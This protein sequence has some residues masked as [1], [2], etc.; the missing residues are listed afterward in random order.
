[1]KPNWIKVPPIPG[2]YRSLLKWGDPSVMKHPTPRLYE[3]LKMTFA[4]EDAD[5]QKPINP[6]D[7]AI[8]KVLPVNLKKSAISFFRTLLGE[9]NILTDSF[10][11]IKASYGK[12]TIDAWRLRDKRVEHVPDVVLRPRNAEDVQQIV[13][14][15][16]RNKIAIYPVGGRSS[17]TAAFEAVKKGI[18]LDMTA[19]MN[20]VLDFDEQNQTITVEPGMYGPELEKILQQSRKLFLTKHDYTCGHFPQSFEF[21]T[22]GGWVA[23]FSSGQQSTYYGDFRDMV[24]AQSYVT[25]IGRFQTKGFPASA[26]GP[27]LNHIFIGSEG[28]FG[29]LVAITI[30]IF[31]HQPEGTRRFSFM[32]RDWQSALTAVRE[33]SQAQ[34]GLPSLFRLSD[35]EETAIALK[36]YG[37]EGTLIDFYLKTRGYSS[38]ARCLVLGQVDGNTRITKTVR[39]NISHICKKNGGLSTTGYV[40]EKWEK[41][42]FKDPYLREDLQDYGIIIDTL[43]CSVSWSNL[44][45]VHT[46]VRRYVKKREQTIL[47]SHASH[48]YA[49]GTNLYFIYIGRFQDETEYLDF[50]KGIVDTMIKAGGSISHHHGIGKMFAPWL[51]EFLGSHE[52]QLLKSIK[53]YLDPN[54]IMNPGG[55]LALD[56]NFLF[57]KKKK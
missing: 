49:Q 2:S 7:E 31:R 42:R 18:A 33:V 29:V 38:G 35:A 27:D 47:M 24:V 44:Q 57:P 36:L 22:V 25:P 1:M 48:F 53:N 6:G 39:R 3:F 17:V 11:R 50:Q 46:Q 5:F 8:E 54:L 51:E 4:M 37:I 15:A 55:T 28:T 26:T 56:S 12:S 10:S 19:F 30:K 41:G 52:L 43:E 20:R 45:Q 9:E 16:S 14:F 34:A 32:F 23:T 13:S 40:V 21:S